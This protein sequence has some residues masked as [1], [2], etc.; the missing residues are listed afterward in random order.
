M[1]C[2]LRSFVAYSVTRI[3]TTNSA[4][5]VVL[6][7]RGV[8]LPHRD[9]VLP[10]RGVVLPH[11]GVALPHRGVVLPHSIPIY[12]VCHNTGQTCIIVFSIDR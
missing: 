3:Y 12:T 8:V 7:H 4:E 1:V 2:V 11:R 10:H 6:P 9:V 5:V